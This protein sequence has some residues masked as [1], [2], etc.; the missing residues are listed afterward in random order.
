MVGDDQFWSMSSVADHLYVRL[1]T[2]RGE[3]GMSEF[4]AF[5]C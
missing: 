5:R 4:T 2:E 1:K 3:K